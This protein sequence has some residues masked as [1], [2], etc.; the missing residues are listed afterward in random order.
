[1]NPAGIIIIAIIGCILFVTS[2]MLPHIKIT[3]KTGNCN[4]D[5]KY[6]AS[7][8]NSKISDLADISADY[9]NLLRNKRS[10]IIVKNDAI[11]MNQLNDFSEEFNYHCDTC[12]DYLK[13]A[14]DCLDV[15][16]FVGMKY[17]IKQ[18]DE[19]MNQ[20]EQIYDY[21]DLLEVNGNSFFGQSD[22]SNNMSQDS[23]AKSDFKM[24]FFY[25]CETKEQINARYK[26]LA[27]V[28]HPD[29]KS[30]NTEIFRILREEYERMSERWN[31]EKII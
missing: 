28:F 23:A 30:G 20:L 8:Y 26:G 15:K 22:K 2:I 3:K 14:R 27:K 16:D 4:N 25:G 18:F 9:L 10:E 7:I 5:W 19:E 31:I 21:I 1:M 29:A 13:R 24:D 17:C 6:Y 12:Q 11:T